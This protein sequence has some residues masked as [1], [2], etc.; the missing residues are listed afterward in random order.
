MKLLFKKL[1]PTAK[2]PARAHKTDAGLDLYVDSTKNDYSAS[3][4]N[5]IYGSGIAVEI[6]IGH[7]GLLFPRSSVYKAGQTLTNCVGVIDAGY[8][9]E[10]KAVFRCGINA[11]AYKTGDRFA[12]LVIVPIPEV[13]LVEA[14]ELSDSDRGEGGYGST[15]R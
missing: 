11:R 8:R 13:E 6:P 4:R 9:G 14:D 1:T 7:V 12:Q 15:G 5:V 10:V 2:M 3:T